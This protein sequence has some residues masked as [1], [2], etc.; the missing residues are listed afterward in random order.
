MVFRKSNTRPMLSVSFS[1]FQNLEKHVHDIG[2][3]LLNFV[4]EH[5][6]IGLSANLLRQL[7]ALLITDVAWRRAHKARYGKLLHVFT[8]VELDEG[9]LIPEHVGGNGFGKQGFTNSG[10]AQ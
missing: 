2:M 6:G 10:G 9:F 8:H 7:S 1:F 5:H 3:R 4:K